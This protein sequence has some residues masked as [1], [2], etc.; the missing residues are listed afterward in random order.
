MCLRFL[1]LS[2]KSLS[3]SSS[4]MEAWERMSETDWSEE[5]FSLSLALDV[6]SLKSL[7]QLSESDNIVMAYYFLLTPLFNN[8][9][10]FWLNGS[11]S[12]GKMSPL[13]LTEMKLAEKFETGP[14]FLPRLQLLAR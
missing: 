12:G 10:G 6:F 1:A 9:A 7:S 5:T 14:T 13:N 3:P 11:N 2:S 4:A 8:S